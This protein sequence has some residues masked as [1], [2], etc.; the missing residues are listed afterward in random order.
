MQNTYEENMRPDDVQIRQM[1]V[2]QAAAAV[3]V[4]AA[5]AGQATRGNRDTLGGFFP[6][7]SAS[8]SACSSVTMPSGPVECPTHLMGPANLRSRTEVASGHGIAVAR[9]QVPFRLNGSQC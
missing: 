5:S 9:F 7:K 2:A 8:N 6:W 4:Q 1:I 3:Q